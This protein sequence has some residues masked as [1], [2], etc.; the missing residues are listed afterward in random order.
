MTNTIYTK[1]SKSKV[2]PKPQ[3]PTGRRW[4]SFPIALSQTPAYAA[5]PRIR[6]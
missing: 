6:G 4:S 1:K 3:G 5:R 2:L